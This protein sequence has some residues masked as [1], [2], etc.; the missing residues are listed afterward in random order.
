MINIG[1][2]LYMCV[3]VTLDVTVTLRVFDGFDAK[4]NILR[5]IFPSQII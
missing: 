1:E 5:I 3:L 4:I 2:G